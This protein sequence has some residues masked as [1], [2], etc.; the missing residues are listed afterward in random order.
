LTV[1]WAVSWELNVVSIV[2]ILSIPIFVPL[3]KEALELVSRQNS[4]WVKTQTYQSCPV[5]KRR[6]FKLFNEFLLPFRA[7]HVVLTELAVKDNV[8]RQNGDA[9]QAFGEDAE[10]GCVVRGDIGD[11]KADSGSEDRIHRLL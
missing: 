5:T 2:S 8:W 1:A 10:G 7:S 6:R 11:A 3:Q 9:W 4:V